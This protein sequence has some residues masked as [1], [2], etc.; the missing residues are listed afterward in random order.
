M[1]V[2]RYRPH[3]FV[4][5][6]DDA[7]R[8]LAV[9]F[10]LATPTSQI[11]VLPVAGGWTNVRDRFASDHVRSMEHYI[12]RRMILLVDFDNDVNRLRAMN[13]V[14]PAG[15][16]DRVFVLGTL[17]RP[18]HLRQMHGSYE[19][20]GRSMAQECSSGEHAIWDSNLLRHNETELVRLRDGVC[21]FL[22]DP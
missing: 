5:P 7:N 18:E 17:T 16:L 22:F 14:I 19:T 3:L 9:G 21:G 2:N 12:D 15:L 20:I 6:E 4:L 13:A 1:S 11:Q 8:Q 10:Q